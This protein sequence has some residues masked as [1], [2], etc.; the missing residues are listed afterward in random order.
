MFTEPSWRLGG[1]ESY[2]RLRPRSELEVD[3]RALDLVVIPAYGPGI[4][5]F[6]GSFHVVETCVGDLV[7]SEAC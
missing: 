5:L 2:F 1:L 7:V 3:V 6:K 4:A